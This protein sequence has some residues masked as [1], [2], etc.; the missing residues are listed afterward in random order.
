MKKLFRIMV[1][2]LA[3]TPCFAQDTNWYYMVYYPTSTVPYITALGANYT[4]DPA[5]TVTTNDKRSLDFGSMNI[6]NLVVT[7]T[8]STSNL[9]VNGTNI[10]DLGSVPSAWEINLAGW[11]VP[12]NAFSYDPNWLTN[13]MGWLVP[14]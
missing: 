14:K 5:S 2:L 8:A 6:S 11:L 4:N 10:L 3:A 7:G 1:F 9:L 12:R 13:S